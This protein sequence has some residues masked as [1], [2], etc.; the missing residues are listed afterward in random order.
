MGDSLILHGEQGHVSLETV[1]SEGCHC[2][3]DLIRLPAALPGD[4]QRQS[5]LKL[6]RYGSMLLSSLG[7]P[8][9]P[10]QGALRCMCSGTDAVPTDNV[11]LL[12][13]KES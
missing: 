11:T 12:S 5:M 2:H 6:S 13:L 8:T 7:V 4:R 10:D 3:T 9:L 1:T